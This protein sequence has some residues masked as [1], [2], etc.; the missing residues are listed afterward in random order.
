[1]TKVGKIVTILLWVLL[2]VSAVLVVSMMVNISGNEADPTMNSWINSNLVWAY[3]L[4]AVGAGLAILAGLFHMV[5]D[6]RAAKKGII[7][8]A[9]MGA[10]VL[11]AYLFASDAIP[12]FAGVQKFIDNGTL[13]SQVAKL[14]DTGLNV[15]YILL[16]LALLSIVFSSVTRLFK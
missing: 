9:F 16:G 4:L 13:T 7:A 5:T 8:L 15:T 2:I 10:V 6:M 3:I 11:V 12:Q 14:V 1:M